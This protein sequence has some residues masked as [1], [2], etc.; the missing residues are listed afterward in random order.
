M[1][2]TWFVTGVWAPLGVRS[3]VTISP[4]DIYEICKKARLQM[5][6]LGCM[7]TNVWAPLDERSTVTV[8]VVLFLMIGLHLV[9][10]RL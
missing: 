2:L 7:F 3:T 4:N 9:G 10:E 1:Q 8:L 5:G 6:K